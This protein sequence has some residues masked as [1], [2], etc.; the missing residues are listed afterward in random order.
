MCKLALRCR[1]T[2]G[3]LHSSRVQQQTSG[4]QFFWIVPFRQAGGNCRRR[5]GRWVRV[6]VQLRWLCTA[7]SFGAGEGASPHVGH[8]SRH[9]KGICIWLVLHA[10]R[11]LQRW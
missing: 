5:L 4:V 3:D 9:I 7:A 1:P 8:T 6:W 10:C 2:E 11:C